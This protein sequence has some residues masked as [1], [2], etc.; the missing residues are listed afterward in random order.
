MIAILRDRLERKKVT[1]VTPILASQHDP[2]LPAGFADL[3]LIVNTFH[4]F[5]SGAVYLRAVETCLKPRGRVVNIDF[6]GGDLPVG[7]PSGEKLSRIDFL[8]LA[9]AVGFSVAAEH[10]FLPYQYFVELKR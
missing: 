9:R 2:R 6:H 4:H 5:P 8:K 1:N 10:T 7:P 3:V